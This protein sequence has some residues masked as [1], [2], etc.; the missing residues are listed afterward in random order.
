M[1]VAVRTSPRVGSAVI[2][3][4]WDLAL[5]TLSPVVRPTLLTV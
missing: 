2:D 3:V 5:V 1:S 4:A